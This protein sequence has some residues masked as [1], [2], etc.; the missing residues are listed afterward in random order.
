[1]LRLLSQR[2]YRDYQASVIENSK[3]A[4]R[5]VDRLAPELYQDFFNEWQKIELIFKEDPRKRKSLNGG[6]QGITIHSSAGTVNNRNMEAKFRIL[7][8]QEKYSKLRKIFFEYLSLSYFR[9]P[10]MVPPYT[11]ALP[12]PMEKGDPYREKQ[13]LGNFFY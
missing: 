8:A 13:I 10:P 6:F 4:W 7:V 5:E 1:M 3:L 11:G 9:N 12:E 2:R